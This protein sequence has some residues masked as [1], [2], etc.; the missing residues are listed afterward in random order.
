MKGRNVLILKG[1]SHAGMKETRMKTTMI[2][3]TSSDVGHSK[4]MKKMVMIQ[5][6]RHR[7]GSQLL[8]IEIYFQTIIRPQK[9]MH[10]SVT[11]NYI[12]TCL[13]FLLR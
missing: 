3:S 11:V 9:Y 6:I 2:S 13:Y 1:T 7:T 10:P 5:S 8:H 12:F 4:K